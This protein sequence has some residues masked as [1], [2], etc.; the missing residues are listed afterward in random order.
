MTTPPTP[1]YQHGG[2]TIYHGDCRQIVSQLGTFDL[3]L[4]DPPYGIGIAANPVRQKH[5]SLYADDDVR[6]RLK[7]ELTRSMESVPA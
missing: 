4:T 1:F 2:I 6:M 5:G 7:L 3:L